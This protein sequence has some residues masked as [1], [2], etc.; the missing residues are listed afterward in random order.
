[1]SFESKKKILFYAE[2]KVDAKG[3]PNGDTFKKGTV[4]GIVSTEIKNGQT[5]YQTDGWGKINKSKFK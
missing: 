5:I 3:S 1:M 2:L 4:M